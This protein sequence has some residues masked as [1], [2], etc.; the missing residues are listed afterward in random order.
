LPLSVSIV[1][2]ATSRKV[3]GQIRP[4]VAS[5]KVLWT[6]WHGRMPRDAEDAHWEWDELMDLAQV[7]PEQFAV[8]ALEAEGELQGLRMLEVSEDDVKAHGT[9]A[10]RLST[11]PWNRSPENR[12]RGVGS[13]LVGTAILRSLD[14]GHQGCAHCESLPKAGPFHEQNGMVV[15]NGLSSEGL[16]RYR[17]TEET[18]RIFVGRLRQEGLLH[19]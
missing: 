14:D 13:L 12:Y 15:F 2:R 16:R 17:F 18:A 19:G 11:A 7:M 8:Y 1:E 4:A 10:L 9:H 6:R 3:P 5:D